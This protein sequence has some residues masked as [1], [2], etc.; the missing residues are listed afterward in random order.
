MNSSVKHFSRGPAVQEG[1]LC[2]LGVSKPD[3]VCGSLALAL[4]KSQVPGDQGQRIYDEPMSLTERLFAFVHSSLSASFL[5]HLAHAKA[6][7]QTGSSLPIQIV[8]SL[9]YSLGER[10]GK[11]IQTIEDVVSIGLRFHKMCLAKRRGQVL[12]QSVDES[13][14]ASNFPSDLN[15]HEK[16]LCLITSRLASVLTS[17]YIDCHGSCLICR[18]A[19][20]EGDEPEDA[21]R[22]D[23]GKSGSCGPGIPN[24]TAMLAYPPASEQRLQEVH[25]PPSHP[26]GNILSR[27]YTMGDGLQPAF[28]DAIQLTGHDLT[29]MSGVDLQL[30]G[31]ATVRAWEARGLALHHLSAGDMAEALKAMT[32]SRSA[33]RRTRTPA[34]NQSCT[35][36]KETR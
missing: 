2:D 20:P 32:A 5:Q 3:F 14:I 15:E 16:S 17:G 22:N 8:N 13:A 36:A 35:A 30:A 11:P 12:D 29:S 18:L 34:T 25:L 21:R 28:G 1:R 7:N 19:K 10:E 33:G 24:G 23:C 26:V 31:P 6:A 27:S 4:Y 9:H